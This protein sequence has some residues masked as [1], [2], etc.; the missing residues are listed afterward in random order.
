VAEETTESRCRSW[1]QNGFTLVE[2]LLA[3]TITALIVVFMMRTFSGATATWRQSEERTDTFR[4]AR[5]AMEMMARDLGKTATAFKSPMLV[6]DFTPGS[7]ATDKTANQEVY[8]IASI[9]N[10]GKTDLCTV[11]YYCRWDDKHY[12]YIL[13]RF[14]LDGDT[15]F[16]NF[17]YGAATPILFDSM[18]KSFGTY[19]GST[20][21]NSS[22]EED[23]A[24][25]V[26]DMRFNIFKDGAAV[27]YPQTY[28]S[29][30]SDTLPAWIEVSFKAIGVQAAQRLNALP[31]T[32][33]TW[34]PASGTYSSTY[35]HLILPYQQQFT[36]RIPLDT[37]R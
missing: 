12:C 15:T 29:N 6:L 23:V 1:L 5:A 3:M 28:P 10:A 27:T 32:R 2:L 4:E 37:G 13:K 7:I 21:K 9:P 36:M 20:Y 22:A 8:A 19:S 34:N 24:S 31:I 16:N 35:K 17:K 11:G 26:W 14:F 30:Y 33:D 18:Y 25:Y